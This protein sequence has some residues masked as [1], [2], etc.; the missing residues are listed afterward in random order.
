ML[1]RDVDG[2]LSSQLQL[3][4]GL[5]SWISLFDIFPFSFPISNVYSKDG[6]G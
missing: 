6:K 2:Y 1:L 4:T 3:L 5:F